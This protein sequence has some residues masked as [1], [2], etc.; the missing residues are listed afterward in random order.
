MP[1]MDATVRSHIVPMSSADEFFTDQFEHTFN[2]NYADDSVADLAR[3]LTIP[4][5]PHFTIQCPIAVTG[6]NWWRFPTLNWGDIRT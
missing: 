5:P 2:L 1:G 3:E 4:L 6:K